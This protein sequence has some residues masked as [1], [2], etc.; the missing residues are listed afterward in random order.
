MRRGLRR[1]ATSLLAIGAAAVLAALLAGP[2]PA[3]AVPGDPDTGFSTDG[4]ETA[5]F[6]S[7][8]QFAEARGVAAQS[9]GK[10]VLGGSANE[11][12]FISHFALIRLLP[13]G[14]QDMS[15]GD[16][17][18]TKVPVGANDLIND[19]AVYP[20]DSDPLTTN[21][22][23]IVAVGFATGGTS[24]DFAVARF[25]ASGAP[26]TTFGPGGLGY[27]RID[28]V[29][30]KQDRANSVAIQDDGKILISGWT[31]GDTTG[32]D[33]AVVRLNTNGTLDTTFNGDGKIVTSYGTGNDDGN[34]VMVVGTGTTRKILVGGLV[35]AASDP[36]LQPSNML[37]AQYTNLGAADATF[38]S[39]GVSILDIPGNGCPSGYGCGEEINDLAVAPDGKIAAAGVWSNYPGNVKTHMVAARFTST[40]AF[41]TTFSSDGYD[42]TTVAP[43]F[44]TDWAESV[45]VQ[46]DGKIVTF[47]WS[48]QTGADHD[49]IFVRHSTDGTKDTAYSGDGIAT[50]ELSDGTSFDDGDAMLL[51]S[52]GR[53][54]GVGMTTSGSN[55]YI[56]ATRLTTSGTLDIF[57]PSGGFFITQLIG[58]SRDE[59]TGLAVQSTGKLVVAG[60]TDVGS[61][62][63][64]FG[65]SRFNTNGTLDTT[66]DADGLFTWGNGTQVDTARAV[67]IQPSDDKILVAGDSYGSLAPSL[68]IMRFLPN[69]GPDPTFD[70]DGVLT[71][72]Y[73]SNATQASAIAVDAAGRIVI[74]GTVSDAA[75]NWDVLVARY[76]ANG[77][78]DT[79]FDADGRARLDIGAFD[80]LR[81]IAIQPDG[82]IVVGGRSSSGSEF[83]F[84]LARYNADGSRDTSFGSPLG[85]V[86]TRV[87]DPANPFAGDEIRGLSLLSEGKIVVGGKALNAS[88]L[89]AFALARYNANGSLD[90]SL[91]GDGTAFTNFG[92]NR[93]DEINGLAVQFD[94]K[95]MA[96]GTGYSLTTGA[97]D[98]AVARFNWDDG[99]LDATYGTG[100]VTMTD[101]AGFDRASGGIVL[102]GGKSAVAG[103]SGSQ[104]FAAARYN[105]DPPPTIP[106]VPDLAATSDSGISAT[107]NITNDTTPTVTGTCVTGETV[108]LE[109]NGVDLSPRAR[110]RCIGSAYSVTATQALADGTAQLR[111][112]SINGAGATTKTTTLAVT[113]DT[114]ALPPTI[115]AP[116][117]GAEVNP[118]PTISGAGAEASAAVQVREGA[119]SVCSATATAAPAWSCASS[120]TPGSHTITATQTDV[121]GN[122]STATSRTFAVKAPT[123]TT[124]ASSANP[125]VFGQPV[126]F[127]ATVGSAGYGT[128]VGTVRFTVDGAAPVDVALTGGQATLTRSN[129]SVAAHT[130][131]AQYLGATLYF[132]STATPLGQTVNKASTSTALF[133]TPTGSVYGQSVNVVANVTTTAPGAGIPSGTVTF[134]LDGTQIASGPISALDGGIGINIASLTVGSHTFGASYSGST[135]HNPSTAPPMTF[136][137][138]RAATTTTITGDAPDPSNPGAPVTVSFA[139]AV[140]A[141]GAGN[142]TGSVTVSA[143]SD[144]CTAALPA[145]SCQLTF[146][147]TS[148]TITAAYAGSGNHE[149]S[150][151]APEPH[152]VNRYLSTTQITSISPSPALVGEI[153]TVRVAVSPV[154]PAIATPT[155]VVLVTD[156]SASCSTT[157]AVGECQLGSF[158]AGLYGVS[159]TYLGD[160]AFS[161]SASTPMLH[162]VLPAPS[163]TRIT[164]TSP[165]P[166]VTGEAVTVS[167]TVETPP[168]ALGFPSGPVTVSTGDESCTA[169]AALGSCTIVFTAAGS[170]PLTAA[171]A[172]DANVLPSTSDPVTHQVDR[173]ATST[174]ITATSP[175]DPVSGQ[176]VTVGF[177]VT[178]N[179]PGAGQPTG[180]VTVSDGAGATCTATVGD[181]SCDLTLAGAGDHAL[182][183]T[184]AGDSSFAGSTS[185]SFPVQVGR[186]P[187]ATAIT[188]TAPAPSVAG[189]T[190]TASFVVAPAPPGSGAPAGTVVVSDGSG[191]SC[192]A[193]V[194]DGSCTLT[195][196]TAGPR[197]LTASYAGNADFA[198]STSAPAAHLVNRAPTAATVTAA[199]PEPSIEGDPVAIS[200]TVIAAAPGAGTPTG[201]VTIG[202][203]TRSCTAS[204]AAGSCTITFPAPATYHLTAT[205]AGDADFDGSTSSPFPHVVVPRNLPP[206]AEAGGPYAVAEGGSVVLDGS[207]SS[208]PES[209]VL[210]YAWDLDGDALFGETGTGAGRGDEVGVAPTF[211][212]GTI[213][214]PASAPVALHVTDDGGL[215]A[216][217]SATVSVANA[218]PTAH[219][220]GGP[221]LDATAGTPITVGFSATDPSASD[222]A[223]G[224]TY[225]IDWGDGTTET[226]TGPATG[227]SRSHTYAHLGELTVAATAT[228]QDAATSPP[229]SAAVAVGGTEV[230]VDPN[231]P[232]RTTTVVGGGSG[233][234][235][236]TVTG[237]RGS[238][239]VVVNGVTQT[240]AFPVDGTLIVVAGAGDDT[241][242]IDSK[243][244]TRSIIAAGRGNDRVGTGNS[245]SVVIGGD[246]NDRITSGNARDLLIGGAGAD[247]LGGGSGDDILVGGTTAFDAAT[248]ANLQALA[249]IA[250]EW[251]RMDLDYQTRLQHVSGQVAGGLNGANALRAA[252]SGR[253][254]FDDA[255]ADTLTGGNGLDWFLLNLTATA[256]HPAD[257]ADIKRGEVSTDL[258]QA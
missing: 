149:P 34:A 171:F 173:S 115:T 199:S 65:V 86:R 251:R 81:S 107:D 148:T 10:L 40:G 250:Q 179:A 94:E 221:Q 228:D 202:D 79:T 141:P 23:K 49:F 167:F 174:V 28:V 128:P 198:G 51:D 253:T 7:V 246:G 205:Y 131:G 11:G 152:T 137:V 247:T 258:E 184:Y 48:D 45:A 183:A 147:G 191:A 197:T 18:R 233:D 78:P 14:H 206:V 37:M 35:R 39:S 160:S 104:D 156:G 254:V 87:S 162:Q 75:G 132:P 42:I 243:V 222:T 193:T 180:D 108:V 109:V 255:S 165:D 5:N 106:S 231:D 229:A 50:V 242:T 74:A 188:G 217:D 84:L 195:F 19:V 38:G 110:A 140:V 240:G 211:V 237:G 256:G 20:A 55:S 214:G 25:L 123:T 97:Q 158:S 169:P 121:A 216:A 98:I 89:N 88:G 44:F 12:G 21:D 234:D 189:E 6:G 33:V 144:S 8:A 194:A 166:S 153:A 204:V 64:D 177:G 138:Q 155:G 127:T 56:G 245:S 142:P 225:A 207:A 134:T 76:N 124:L 4:E 200:F 57:G 1:R 126:T 29:D 60:W 164:G 2:S 143:G 210:T 9:D 53:A 77:T 230:I 192:S 36:N 182:V 105:G 100:G 3:G 118:L 70:G 151:S 99:S 168:P 176:L 27:F 136:V 73:G 52:A 133:A 47:G 145:T 119:A 41:D 172:G 227:V 218:A 43:S 248:G 150:T 190:V 235:A 226:V 102:A 135:S 159:A 96:Y 157:V 232:N 103:T 170:R 224:F 90:T 62:N 223:A 101:I 186:S 257:V 238:L 114:V 93:Q 212:V 69:G 63:F 85:Y 154:P 111:T 139:V 175:A 219:V 220:A 67:A 15:F 209:G 196:A 13:T 178:A 17:G 59:A 95:I 201:T 30:G 113:I 203:G 213:D 82:K 236:V 54:V 117:A 244:T 241:I 92:T 46:A 125:S 249:A 185:P 26:D 187:T 120:L 24:D 16:G 58:G 163:V 68:T 61:N 146:T 91:A 32:H 181:G 161:G 22:D 71:A 129:L 130:V 122:T 83:L 215:T 239:Q 208:D 116:A 252:G 112:Y 31:R 66:F 80:E 72:T